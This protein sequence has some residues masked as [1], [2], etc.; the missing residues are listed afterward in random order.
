MQ[1]KT[2]L[3]A[4]FAAGLMGFGAAHAQY[5]AIVQ[6]APPAPRYEVVPTARPGHVWSPGHYEW[7]GR[8]YAWVEGRWL[9][10]RNGYEYREPRWVQRGNGEW[11]MVGGNWERGRY[12]DRDHDGVANR[13]DRDRDN[14]GVP[15]HRDRYPNNPRRS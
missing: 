10:A 2:L 6:V 15:N 1:R 12:G 4:A 5:T 9:S 7:R 11:M 8:E 14:D 3:A 13:H